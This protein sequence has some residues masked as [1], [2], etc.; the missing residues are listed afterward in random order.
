MAE[1]SR[2]SDLA[3]RGRQVLDDGWASRQ[4]IARTDA[5]NGMTEDEVAALSAAADVAAVRAYSDAVGW[6]TLALAG[7]PAA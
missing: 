5:G 3:S 4:R 2:D 1:I 6:R 7:F